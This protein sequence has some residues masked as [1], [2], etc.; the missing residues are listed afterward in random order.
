MSETFD[1]STK[2]DQ[3][4]ADA[5]AAAE[6]QLQQALRSKI[7][8][9]TSITSSIDPSG[10]SSDGAGMLRDEPESTMTRFTA[11]PSLGSTMAAIEDSKDALIASLTEELIQS[12]EEVARLTRERLYFKRKAEWCTTEDQKIL[13]PVITSTEHW[14]EKTWL[15]LHEPIRQALLDMSDLII[16]SPSFDP[17]QYPWKVSNFFYYFKTAFAPFVRRHHDVEKKIYIP[18]VAKKA[19]IPEAVNT[20]HDLIEQMLKDVEKSEVEYKALVKAVGAGKAPSRPVT[21]AATGGTATTKEGSNA[22]ATAAPP[23]SISVSSSTSVSQS[24]PQP[25]TTPMPTTALSLQPLQE[26]PFHEWRSTL[27]T[28]LTVLSEHLLAH[29]NE[30][31]AFFPKV[32]YHNYSEK[33]EE[34]ILASMSSA[35]AAHLELPMIVL[36]MDVWGTPELKEEFLKKLGVAVRYTLNT[37]WLSS[38]KKSL[39]R[40]LES[41]AL[42]EAPTFSYIPHM[43]ASQLMVAAPVFL[44]CSIM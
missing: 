27:I 32:V 10:R 15:L 40:S 14:Y 16:K 21:P 6:Q 42:Q 31:E 39:A 34:A 11:V 7:S 35:G 12:K 3:D 30:E 23:S 43:S 24:L 5:V 4:A 26:G 22:D 18:W 2:K 25:Q 17:I 37:Y 20:G 8:F 38:Y 19:E 29:L 36:A 1:N 9:S 41:L 44:L 33:E 28:R 13:S